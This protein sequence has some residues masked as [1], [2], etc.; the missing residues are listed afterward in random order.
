MNTAVSC[1]MLAL[2]TVA[3]AT[4]PGAIEALKNDLGVSRTAF[5]QTHPS[6]TITPFGTDCPV[7]IKAYHKGD[8]VDRISLWSNPPGA[9]CVERAIE[10]LTK[11]FGKPGI[12]GYGYATVISPTVIAHSVHTYTWC[13][14]D[15]DIVITRVAGQSARF[16]LFLFRPGAYDPGSGK[17]VEIGSAEHLKRCVGDP[18]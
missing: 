1:L 9:G 18:G 15:H 8:A 13:L 2:S 4:S 6:K 14:T 3:T 11:A 17:A 7:E 5:K 12:G 16:S 10:T